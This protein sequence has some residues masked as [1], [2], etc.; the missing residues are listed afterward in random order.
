MKNREKPN[1]VIDLNERRINKLESEL[2]ENL[3]KRLFSEESKE[4]KRSDSQ[5]KNNSE[6]PADLTIHLDSEKEQIEARGSFEST[7]HVFESKRA[8]NK[9]ASTIYLLKHDNHFLKE[10]SVL[11]NDEPA[12]NLDLENVHDIE[13]SEDGE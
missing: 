12:S 8:Q 6:I 13:D 3:R 2:E 11:V 7:G 5:E 1:N 9:V 4:D 10:W